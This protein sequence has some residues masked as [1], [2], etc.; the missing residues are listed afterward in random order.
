MFQLSLFRTDKPENIKDVVYTPDNIAK[1]IVTFFRPTG[2]CLDP[3]KGKGAFLQYLPPN[4]NWCEITE[5]INF[6]EFRRKV[7]WIISN[8][9]YSQFVKWML[10]SF[11]IA[12]NIVYLIPIDKPFISYNFLLALKKYGGIKSIYIIGPGRVC[13]FNFGFAVGAVYFRRNYSGNIEIIFRNKI[14]NKS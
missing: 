11:E 14:K 3:C 7:D 6:F 13:N 1:E 8:P 10:H 12:D 9:P 4:S 2:K 5:G